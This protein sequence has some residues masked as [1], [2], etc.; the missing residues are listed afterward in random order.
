VKSKVSRLVVGL[1]TLA[2]SGGAFAGKPLFL[3]TVQP[4]GAHAH[5]AQALANEPANASVRI[6]RAD[7]SAVSRDTAELDLDLGRVGVT[8]LLDKVQT[9]PSGSQVWFGHLK[10]A[11]PRPAINKEVRRDE[12]NSVTLVRR[13]NGITGS[14]RVS[15]KLYRIQPMPDGTHAVIEV[16]ES[17]MPDEHPASYR[18]MFDKAMR[19]GKLTR[20]VSAD[21]PPGTT[22]TIRVGVVASAQAVAGY[23]GD[24]QALMELAVA[25]TNTGYTNSNIGIN[26]EL[27]GY[28][29]DSYSEVGD[30]NTDLSRFSGTSD[31]YLDGYHATR[32][33]IAADVNVLIINS[34]SYCGLGYLNSSASSA[35]VVVSRGCATGYYSFAHELGHNMGAHHDPANGS[36]SIYTYGHGY[37]Y[38]NSWRT[39]MAYNCPSNCPRLN[40]W[41]S[42]QITYG[43]V[44]MGNANQSDNRRVLIERKATVA[45]FR[46]AAANSA[47][48]ANF[49]FSTSNLTATF[50]DGSSDSDGTIVSR[51]WN[52]GDA[53][54]STATHPS[55]TYATAGTYSVTLTVTDDDGA[56]HSV[57]KSVTVTAP[58]S[59]Q[60]YTNATDF[61]INDNATVDSP[62][63]VS[64]RTGNAPSNAAVQV[65]ILH[66]FK[67]DLKVQL[68]APDGSAYLLHNR[69]GGSADNIIQ[70]YTVNLSAEA[71]NGIWKLRVNDNASG[72]T[73]K[74][75]SWSITF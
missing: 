64:G 13:G 11:K 47:P 37:Q 34:G 62:I 35:F 53:S 5:A 4:Q 42:P 70:T 22:Q 7:A 30:F 45:A 61:A 18:T 58:P 6:V 65:T 38:G 44:A 9:N 40:Y 55:R 16:D 25:E 63:T 73:G 46:S 39:I 26:M 1:A 2:L 20:T 50:T 12:Q 68:I 75:D 43:G 23:A 15:G 52:F 33:A 49:S 54:S 28:Y 19:E 17:K 48:V 41:S 24:M 3:G 69:T 27:A 57:T 71:L 56:T 59:R 29:A 21:T 66:T 72:D 31:G 67:G 32:D 74:I 14:V 36:N 60:T 10:D 51:N 8:A